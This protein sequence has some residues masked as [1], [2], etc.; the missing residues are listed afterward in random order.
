[1]GNRFGSIHCTARA[2]S[3]RG[4]FDRLRQRPIDS[5]LIYRADACEADTSAAEFGTRCDD[6]LENHVSLCRAGLE[7]C[8]PRMIGRHALSVGLRP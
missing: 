6:F 4:N 1:M 3:S 5:F 7:A 2:I 8:R